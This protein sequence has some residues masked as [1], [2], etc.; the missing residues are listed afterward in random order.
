MICMTEHVYRLI[1]SKAVILGNNMLCGDIA[2]LTFG[3]WAISS[4]FQLYRVPHDEVM[5][6][7]RHCYTTRPRSR[8]LG[9]VP[10]VSNVAM[11]ST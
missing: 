4:R 6:I 5:P 9:A 3:G 1:D 11:L 2:K 8:S 7:L 10:E